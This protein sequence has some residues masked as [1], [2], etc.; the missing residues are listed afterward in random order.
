MRQW[1]LLVA[2]SLIVFNL[3]AQ[4]RINRLP[5]VINHP[6]I[7]VSAPYV[8]LDGGS[9]LFLSDNTEDN[10]L[11]VFYSTKAD[12]ITWKEPTPLPRNINTR[13]NFLR[14]YALSA[15]G[16]QLFISSAKGGG[17]GGYDIYASDLKGFWQE[18]LNLGVPVNSP[19]H[20]ACPSLT[21]DGLTMYFMRCTKMAATVAEGCKLMVTRR[22][23][24]TDRWG[25]PEELPATINNGNAQAP[26][27][28]GDSE[29]LIFSSNT[30]SPNRGG[31]DLYLTRLVNNGW[32]APVPLD[33]AN[34]D[35]D[36]QWVSGTS[37]GRYLMKDAP[38]RSASEI[39]EVLFPPEVKPKGVMKLEGKV[40]GPSNPG[41]AYVSVWDK[42]SQTRL[43]S[44]RPAA[45]GSFTLFLK[46]GTDYVVNVDPEQD[47]L[48]FASKEFLMAEGKFNT[49]ERV[50][51]ELKPLT[52]GAF[53]DL[54]NTSFK[55][56]T[57]ELTTSS[58]GELRK[59]VRLIKAN[60]ALNFSVEVALFGYVED[61]VQRDADLT[62]VITD[63]LRIPV[64]RHY[65]DTTFTEPAPTDPLSA[66][67]LTVPGY[68]LTQRTE[69]VDSV[70]VKH[71]YHNDRT[72]YM[73][74][75]IVNY[76]VAQGVPAN[77]LTP[78]HL[79][80]PAAPNERKWRIRIT[81]R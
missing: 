40:T 64:T 25:A 41:A 32:S 56:Y 73:A 14:G 23:T 22:R 10:I 78:L 38:G 18:P 55:P 80:V 62:E 13:Q 81:A 37:L 31:M 79:A 75:E 45:D 68:T 6:S 50:Q 30:L 63:T 46:E 49:T 70:V 26:R 11:G 43:S 8:S 71:R 69:M 1:K 57:A 39:I 77:K 17:V 74:L 52:P 34:S 20:E 29:T 3:P 35:K 12:G 59:L 76:L 60:T 51:F 58:D 66:D 72:A 19:A 54:T 2:G 21:A 65:T 47:N 5:G 9:L 53:I 33:F 42:A 4:P 24:L 28:M 15:D 7:N 27:I 67:S 44:V 48:T 61:T 16:R 36:D